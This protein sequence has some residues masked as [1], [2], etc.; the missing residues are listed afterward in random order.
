[1]YRPTR[2]SRVVN[3]VERIKKVA[4]AGTMMIR[5]ATQVFQKAVNMMNS[6]GIYRMSVT[7]LIDS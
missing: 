7:D 1:M 5:P 3:R 2:P 4:Q 6:S